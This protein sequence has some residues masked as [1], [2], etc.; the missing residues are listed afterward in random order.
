MKRG[1]RRSKRHWSDTD[2]KTVPL[3]EA[4]CAAKEVSE[5]LQNAEGSDPT[6]GL[7]T[8]FKTS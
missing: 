7:L 3:K 8:N 2:Q 4:K 5:E 6:D 1:K